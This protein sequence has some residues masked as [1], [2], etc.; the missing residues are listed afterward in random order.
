M[1]FPQKL[2]IILEIWWP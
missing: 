2:V 1:H